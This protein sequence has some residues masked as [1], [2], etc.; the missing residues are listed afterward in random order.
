MEK[1]H[2]AP[3]TLYCVT[4]ILGLHL[5]DFV[6]CDFIGNFHIIESDSNWSH[7][8]GQHRRGA[9]N[10]LYTI[11]Y[12]ILEDDRQWEFNRISQKCLCISSN[13]A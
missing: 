3:E 7:S 4:L 11:S 13:E 9:S 10:H 12:T 2:L 5:C 1:I 8:F 6:Y